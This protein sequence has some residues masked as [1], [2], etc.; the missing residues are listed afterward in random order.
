MANGNDDVKELEARYRHLDD[1]VGGI[2][3]EVAGVK[4]TLDSVVNTLD[5]IAKRVNQ[6]NNTQ[7]SPI[8]AAIGLAFSVAMAFTALSVKPLQDQ[9]LRVADRQAD[10]LDLGVKERVNHAAMMGS[11]EAKIE[12]EIRENKEDDTSMGAVLDALYT[13]QSRLSRIEGKLGKEN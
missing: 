13:V 2:S 4:A 10:S 7:W 5:T 3:R 11:M 9:L 8:I 6:P 1:R 12:Q